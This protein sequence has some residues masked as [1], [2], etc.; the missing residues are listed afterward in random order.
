MKTIRIEATVKIK[1]TKDEE[2]IMKVI[3]EIPYS[4]LVFKGSS[5]SFEENLEWTERAKEVLQKKGINI[6]QTE[7][8]FI[9]IEEQVY[10]PVIKQIAFYLAATLTSATSGMEIL[11]L[12]QVR[13]EE[14][15]K[16]AVEILE[17]NQKNKEKWR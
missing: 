10:G 8:A 6:N 1:A 13:L 3:F 2:G 12:L 16:E 4:E 9:K 11:S 5:P 15:R 17:R 7:E 14:T